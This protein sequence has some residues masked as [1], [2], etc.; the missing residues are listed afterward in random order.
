[1]IS[2]VTYG[3]FIE[4][5]KKRLFN[6]WPSADQAN[7]S[8]NEV[9][10]YVFQAIATVMTT[11]AN[12]RYSVEGIYSTSEAF[13]TT[14]KIALS[15]AT[16]DTD[17]NDYSVALPHPPLNLPMGFSV[18][19]PKYAKGNGVLTSLMLI[20][21]YAK[22]YATSMIEKPTGDYYYVEGSKLLIVTSTDLIATGWK[23]LVPMLSSRSATGAETDTINL[24][25]EALSM[26]FDIVVAK[27]QQRLGI[28]VD[29]VNDG[30]NDA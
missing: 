7:L 6:N 1:M 20:D 14:Y 26:V 30:K 19:T 16:K 2:T 29:L 24:S 17:T 11:L 22:G 5:I 25:D 10:L 21:S 3:T 8:N 4:Q 18:Q 13:I 27:L 15:T 28:P 9:A 23:L 12:Q